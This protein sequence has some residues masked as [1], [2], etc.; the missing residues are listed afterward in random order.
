MHEHS[1]AYFRAK[2]NHLFFAASARARN[3]RNS[4]YSRYSRCSRNKRATVALQPLQPLQPRA[5]ALLPCCLAALPCRQKAR[6]FALMEKISPKTARL[7]Q[8]ESL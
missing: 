8:Q 2:F 3:S 6:S 5:A 1:I 4:R 7:Y